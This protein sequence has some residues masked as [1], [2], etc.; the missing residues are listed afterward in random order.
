VKKNMSDE[1]KRYTLGGV[2]DSA[3]YEAESNVSLAPYRLDKLERFE[4]WKR[5][6]NIN[7]LD[8]CVDCKQCKSCS[9]GW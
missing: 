9:S 7:N 8:L 1:L 3:T 5:R 2:R 6:E 4:F